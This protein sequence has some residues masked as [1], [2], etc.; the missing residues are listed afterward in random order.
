MV[1]ISSHLPGCLHMKMMNN[2]L[3]EYVR[4]CLDDLGHCLDQFQHNHFIV[5]ARVFS[6]LLCAL[7]ALITSLIEVWL[8]DQ[9]QTCTGENGATPSSCITENFGLLQN[10]R[11][12]CIFKSG[13]LKM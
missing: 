7:L 3:F 8:T 4:R 9:D 6:A 12:L 5:H 10:K 13:K 1:D 11:Q 2:F